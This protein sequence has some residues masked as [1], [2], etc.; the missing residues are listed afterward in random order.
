WM[1]MS[2]GRTWQ[3]SPA[4][5]RRRARTRMA[6]SLPAA[7]FGWIPGWRAMANGSASPK[8]SWSR[9]KRSKRETRLDVT[10]PSRRAQGADLSLV[11]RKETNTRDARTRAGKLRATP[12][13]S[14]G[15]RVLRLRQVSVVHQRR[16]RR[17]EY[18]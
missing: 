3:P 8:G 6:N 15:L 18:L 10:D 1:F 2:T 5:R 7:T 14:V 16:V 11:R 12:T 9:A 4:P 17:R 13:V